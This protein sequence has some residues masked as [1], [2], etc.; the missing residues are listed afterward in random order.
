MPPDGTGLWILRA[1]SLEDAQ[2]IANTS[3]RARDGLLADSGRND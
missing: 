2:Q 1:E 3:P